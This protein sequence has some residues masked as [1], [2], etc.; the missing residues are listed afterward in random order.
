MRARVR[1]AAPPRSPEGP[2]ELRRTPRSPEQA[3][4]Y[5][6]RVPQRSGEPQTAPGGGGGEFQCAPESSGKFWRA[7]ESFCD[8][9]R[10]PNNSG[11]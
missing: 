8:L 4:G 7:A 2:R 5:L 1:A 9:Q 10:A 11:D 3:S 6:W